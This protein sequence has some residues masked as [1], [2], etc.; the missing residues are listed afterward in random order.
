MNSDKPDNHLPKAILYQLKL[1]AVA[2]P[3]TAVESSQRT[4]EVSIAG[5]AN[6]KS[7]VVPPATS[8]VE[9]YAH[10][11]ATAHFSC[12]V[13]AFVSDT[14]IDIPHKTIERA[15]NTTVTAM[16]YE[17]DIIPFLNVNIGVSVVLHIP[18][19]G[20]NFVSAGL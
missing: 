5:L 12:S 4:L 17:D 10:S 15:G 1:N 2:K 20:Y 13:S 11:G 19:L 6:T 9:T 7:S 18:N 14:L 16:K 3:K 8:C